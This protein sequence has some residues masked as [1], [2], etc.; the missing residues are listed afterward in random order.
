MATNMEQTITKTEEIAPEKSVASST[1]LLGCVKWFNN[2]RGYGFVTYTDNNIEHDVFVHHTGVQPLNSQY[3][4]LTTGEYVSFVLKPPSTEGEREQAIDVTGVNGGPLLC[5]QYSR[6]KAFLNYD[7]EGEGGEGG[8]GKGV[9]SYDNK[10]SKGG[11]GGK[12]G[13]GGKGSKSS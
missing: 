12:G 8:G 13:R 5:D 10:G 7:D 2:K 4:T 3:R 11:K 1:K 9:T 6:R